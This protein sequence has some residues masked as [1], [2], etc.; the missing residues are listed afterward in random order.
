MEAGAI[1]VEPGTI[2]L[3]PSEK[4]AYRMKAARLA[5]HYIEDA[6]GESFLFLELAA[7]APSGIY[8]SPHGNMEEVVDLGRGNY[9]DRSI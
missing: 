6:P 7:L 8:P 3:I 4:I 1:G 5:F 2:D 9:F